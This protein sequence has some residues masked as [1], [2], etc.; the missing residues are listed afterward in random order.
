MAAAICDLYRVR[1]AAEKVPDDMTSHR[2]RDAQAEKS[3]SSLHISI[4]IRALY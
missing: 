4:P 1:L 3:R 2:K